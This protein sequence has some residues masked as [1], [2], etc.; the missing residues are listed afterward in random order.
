[1]LSS[2]LDG[3]KSF[4]IRLH[5]GHLAY[6]Q[7]FVDRR[8]CC[9]RCCYALVSSE[10]AMAG[11]EIVLTFKPSLTDPEQVD[12]VITIVEAH[13]CYVGVVAMMSI[14]S[15]YSPERISLISCP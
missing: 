4:P 15:G 11:Y 14:P 5:I 8:Q 12:H 3:P 2:L 1:M 9:A 6:M 7:G 13:H 10:D